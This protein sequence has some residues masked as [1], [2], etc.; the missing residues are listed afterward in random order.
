MRIAPRIGLSALAVALAAALAGCGTPGAPLPP[1]L[2][3]PNR[4]E[5]LSAVRTGNQVTLSWV[6]PKKNTDKLLLKGNL[7]FR[8]CRREGPVSSTAACEPVSASGEFTHGAA[9]SFN[10]ALP[11]TLANGSPRALTY[12]VE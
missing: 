12:F 10:E 8:V 5:D 6:M 4:V 7:S 11:A 9:A 1:T 2:N 3:L